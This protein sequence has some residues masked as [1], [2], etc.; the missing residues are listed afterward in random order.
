M[1]INNI[2]TANFF[3]G[4][5]LISMYPQFAD[6]AA[7]INLFANAPFTFL[8]VLFLSMMERVKCWIKPKMMLQLDME[9][10]Y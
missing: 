4:Q 7:M 3:D 1:G 6:L 10:Q 9:P 2:L 5:S 8:P